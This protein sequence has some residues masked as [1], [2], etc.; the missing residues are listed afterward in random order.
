M[1]ILV[2]DK[3]DDTAIKTHLMKYGHCQQTIEFV[4]VALH[5]RAELL[6]NQKGHNRLGQPRQQSA[7]NRPN[8][9]WSQMKPTHHLFNQW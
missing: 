6:R 5:L 7:A 3:L 2:A 8:N 9:R 4:L 1:S